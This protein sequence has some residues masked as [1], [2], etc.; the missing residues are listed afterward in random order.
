M[1]V[2]SIEQPAIAAALLVDAPVAT[3]PSARPRGMGWPRTGQDRQSIESL[4]TQPPFAPPK[5]HRRHPGAYDVAVGWMLDWLLDQPGD[6]WQDRWLA[7]GADADGRRWRHIPVGWLIAR[8]HGQSWAHDWF[9]RALF[10]AFGADLIRPSLRLAC[11]S[12]IPAGQ[13][14]QHHGAA[15]ATPQGS[16]RCKH[17]V[18]PSRTCRQPR[19]P[20]P[21]T[22]HR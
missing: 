3:V 19:P 20:A 15:A 14:D 5:R 6:T 16:H 9:F 8:G 12:A 17:C 2:S 4:L 7:S 13:P 1:T 11:C 21:P 18:R 10:T 22:E